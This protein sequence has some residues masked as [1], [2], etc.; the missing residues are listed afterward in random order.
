MGLIGFL[1]YAE[2]LVDLFSP[3][4]WIFVPQF[5]MLMGIVVMTYRLRTVE[6]RVEPA[7]RSLATD[8]Q[9]VFEPNSV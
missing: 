2:R 4:Q 3:S 8:G 9:M 6:E 5:A 7:W 1:W